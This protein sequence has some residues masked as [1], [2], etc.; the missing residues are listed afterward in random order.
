[1]PEKRPSEHQT[2]IYAAKP[3]NQCLTP[4][5]TYQQLTPVQRRQYSYAQESFG[6][7][8]TAKYGHNFVHTL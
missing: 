6:E 7:A 5:N 4:L 3:Y 1:M 8:A 2:I